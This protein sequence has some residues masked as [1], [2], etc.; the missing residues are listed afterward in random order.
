M[1]TA[2]KL[3]AVPTISSASSVRLLTPKEAVE[4]LCVPEGTLAQWRSQRRGPPLL[5]LEDRLVRYR[6]PDLERYI[7]SKIIEPLKSS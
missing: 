6:R 7:A 4:F 2:A 1:A 5:K 3:G